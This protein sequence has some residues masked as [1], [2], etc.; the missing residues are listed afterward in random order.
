MSR[1]PPAWPR[2]DGAGAAS[3]PTSR[4]PSG[5]PSRV[6]ARPQR[7]RVRRPSSAPPWG[8]STG[9]RRTAASQAAR[10]TAPEARGAARS[11]RC[12]SADA[13]HPGPRARVR[14]SGRVTAR[15]SAGQSSSPPRHPRWCDPALTTRSPESASSRSDPGPTGASLPDRPRSDDQQPAPWLASAPHGA[16]AYPLFNNPGILNPSPSPGARIIHLINPRYAEIDGVACV[17]RIEDLPDVP[18][19][20]VITAPPPTVPGV[21]AAAGARGV[22]AAIIITAGLGHGPGSLADGAR[23]EAR[24]HGLRLV[25]PNCLGIL[26]PRAKLNASFTARSAAPGDLALI[27]QSGAIAAGLVEWAAAR[28]VGFSGVVSLGDQ[29]D[30]DFGDCLDYFALDQ[31]TR[32]ILL[33]IEA[34]SDARK[35]MSAARAAARMKPVVVIKS[36]RHEQG[37]RAAAT[38]TGA[39]AGSD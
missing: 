28:N 9:H 38:H 25:G 17:P 11:A 32:A 20:V 33:Y 3:A 30:V 2:P 8:Q 24:K 27:S 15:S 34:I 31:R 6:G 26:A 22:A 23:L 12:R 14:C 18:D 29:V 16:P 36:G 7:A 35:F 37:A 5:P 4:S 10:A 1:T 39:L 13:S 19:L 21:V